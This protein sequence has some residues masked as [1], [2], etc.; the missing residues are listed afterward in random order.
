VRVLRDQVLAAAAAAGRDPGELTCAYNLEV[1]V[2]ERP[3]TGPSVVTGPADAVA[4]QL[5]GFAGL[6][7]TALNLIPVGPDTAGQVELLARE[8]VPAVRT[9]L[10]P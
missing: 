2:D 4:E 5:I 3:A 10:G 7:F 9:A 1:R 6:G 8:I